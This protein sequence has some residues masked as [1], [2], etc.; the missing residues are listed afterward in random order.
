MDTSDFQ[1]G[2]NRLVKIISKNLI[3]CTMRCLFPPICTRDNI[4]LCQYSSTKVL[5][6]INIPDMDYKK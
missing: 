5:L 6:P 3:I 1:K 4:L 2:Y